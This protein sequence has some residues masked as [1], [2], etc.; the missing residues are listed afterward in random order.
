MRLRHIEV[1]QAVLQ[2]GTLT[3][4]AKLL[5]VSQPA[6]TKLLQH[7]E[8]QL[9]FALFN[10]VRGR[11]QL[12][13]EGELLCARIEKIH[14]Q[15]RDLQRLSA[16]IKHAGHRPLRVVSIP[17]LASALVPQAVTGLSAAFAEAPIELV[18]EHS[19]E[20]LRSLLLRESDI[21]LT[22][23]EVRHPDIQLQCLHR[24]KLRVIAPA[25]WW[26]PALLDKPL[27]VSELAGERMIGILSHDGL[28]RRVRTHLQ[29]LQPEPQTRINVQ[30]YQ[31]ARALVV[32]GHG[33][34]IVDPFTAYGGG[35]NIQIRTL[36]PELDVSLYLLVRNGEQP[37]PIQQAFIDHIRVIADLT[38]KALR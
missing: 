34:A 8:M 5:N 38:P 29:H 26:K 23:Q 37:T 18:T 17:T 21:G 7:A 36:K 15:L 10:R 22:L 3:G 28:G 27:P 25:G 11:L 31:L 19:R 14:D 9:G 13:A 32:D 1:F 4:A 24:D 30:T 33:L 16:S 12:T 6:A 35:N 20:M 2:A